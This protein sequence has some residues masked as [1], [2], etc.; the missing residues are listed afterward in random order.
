MKTKLIFLGSILLV[1][2]IL[3]GCKKPEPPAA[4]VDVPATNPTELQQV[5]VSGE[6][7]VVTKGRENI[8]LGDERIELVDAQLVRQY[9][10]SMWGQ[11]QSNFMVLQDTINQDFAAYQALYESNID[12]L[13]TAKG[14]WEN[15]IEVSDAA[16]DGYE[17]AQQWKTKVPLE[18]GTW[19]LLS[20]FSYQLRFR[21]YGRPCIQH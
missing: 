15:Q 7:F 21:K 10:D 5:T 6:I 11:W 12:Q 3:C 2:T 20:T 18:C 8:P 19:A 9:Y 13:E 16:S 14:Y 17:N 4:K 1:S